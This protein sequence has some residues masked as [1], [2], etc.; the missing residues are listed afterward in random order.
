MFVPVGSGRTF[1]EME[2]AD[3]HRISH[4]AHAFRKLREFLA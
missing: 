3:K 1:G 4:R 2:P